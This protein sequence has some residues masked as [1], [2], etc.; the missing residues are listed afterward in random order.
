MK[1]KEA[2]YRHTLD[3]LLPAGKPAFVGYNAGLEERKRLGLDAME[4]SIA[5]GEPAP[6]V[7]LCTRGLGF[8]LV[9]LPYLKGLLGASVERFGMQTFLSIYRVKERPDRELDSMA[10][11]LRYMAIEI[12]RQETSE[13][14]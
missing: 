13:C 10:R 8:G 4:V 14:A 9:T 7:C 3:L 6:T 12:S 1:R 5:K 11:N 2:P